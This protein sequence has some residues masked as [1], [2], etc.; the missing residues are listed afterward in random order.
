MQRGHSPYRQRRVLTCPD[1]CGSEGDS[2]RLTENVD[3]MAFSKI[4]KEN[5]HAINTCHLSL[6]LKPLMIL[7]NKIIR[8]FELR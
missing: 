6:T 3:S 2:P 8:T 7:S 5:I 4:P 1:V